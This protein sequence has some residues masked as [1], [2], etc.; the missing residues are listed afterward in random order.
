MM[1]TPDASAGSVFFFDIDNCLYPASTGI[2]DEMGRRIHAYFQKL[3]LPDEEASALHKRYY[4]EY[5]L[6]VRG[7][8]KHHDVDPLAYDKEVDQSIPLQNYLKPDPELRKMLQSIRGVRKWAFT[9]AFKVHAN[10][11]LSLLQVDD[12]FEG[13]TYCNYRLPDFTSKPDPAYYHQAMKDAGVTDHRRCYL[14]DDAAKNIDAA[15]KLGWTTVHVTENP[16]AE[17]KHGDFQIRNVKE[18]PTVLP[19]L[20]PEGVN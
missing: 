8:M 13:L 1:V 7:L 14:V 3:D 5:G 20:W 11:V 4:T 19:E 16:E 9:N 17:P 12:Q 18:L 10:R 15:K 2:F 6:A